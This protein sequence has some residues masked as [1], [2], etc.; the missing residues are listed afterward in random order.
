MPRFFFHI[1][2]GASL[3]DP[4]GRELI[5]RQAAQTCAIASM[6]EVLQRDAARIA[7]GE[8]WHMDVTDELGLLL[9]R[10]DFSIVRSAVMMHTHATRLDRGRS[11]P[12]A[13]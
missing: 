1:F 10:L 2:D 4:A 7:P 11:G 8:D 3:F 12:D 13:P 5:D 9:F 6:G